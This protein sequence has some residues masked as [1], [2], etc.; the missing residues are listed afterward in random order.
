[1]L[2]SPVM[3]VLRRPVATLC[4]LA[5]VILPGTA[6]AQGRS[7]DLLRSNPRFLSAFR[8]VVAGV[9]PSVVRVRCDEH[10]TALGIIVGADGW[11]LTKANDLKG[12]ITCR[13]HDGRELVAKLVGVHEP[14]D[15]ALLRLEAKGL[16]AL[17]LGDSSG[18]RAG[19]WVASA[20][21]EEEPV[22]V[23]V[24]SVPTRDTTARGKATLDPA[25]GPY[26]GVALE[27]AEAGVRI[28]EVLSGTGAARAGLWPGDVILRVEGEA[29]ADP[30]EFIEQLARHKVG[31][32]ITL[33]IARDGATQDVRATLQL[34]P[35]SPRS[36]LQNRMGSELSSRRG[37][38]QVILQHDSVLQPSDCGGPLVDLD[39]RVIGINVSR[40][41]RVETWAVPA[42]VVRPLLTELKSGKLAPKE[43]APEKTAARDER[44]EALLAALH[45]RLLLM[46]DVARAKWNEGRPVYDPRREEALLE[47]LATEARAYDVSAAEVQRFFIAQ[48]AAA[49]LLQE[50]LFEDWRQTGQ[51]TFAEVPDLRQVLRPGVEQASLDLLAAFARVQPLLR[52][53]EG[54]ERLRSRAEVV[55]VGEGINDAVRELALQP[56][57]R[58]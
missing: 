30:D 57:L 40:A 47:R 43:P 15:L 18:V 31:A 7:N 33:R 25:K 23:G 13:L 19:H 27:Q 5:L 48:M 49:R 55:L 58:R 28:T 14:H 39:G 24:V 44:I 3:P 36:D 22:A 2:G 6:T 21:L 12:P 11:V 56:L 38:Y 9:N 54:R 32:T 10:D 50:K 4:L 16:A 37:G 46:P 41:G 45:K 26:L 29:I 51:S 1:M 17:Q 42:E 20:G 34:R 8:D 52:Q 35:H 53:P